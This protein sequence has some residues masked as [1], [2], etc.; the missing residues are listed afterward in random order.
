MSETFGIAFARVKLLGLQNTRTTEDQLAWGD[1][2]KATLHDCCQVMFV[3]LQAARQGST[4]LPDMET[5]SHAAAGNSADLYVRPGQLYCLLSLHYANVVITLLVCHQYASSTPY[6]YFPS[7]FCMLLRCLIAT[8]MPECKDINEYERAA[9]GSCLPMSNTS[10][11]KQ[12]IHSCCKQ[13]P[14][15]AS[16]L[17][18]VMPVSITLLGYKPP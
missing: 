11:C 10:I 9:A 4:A 2:N 3:G 16:A 14:G 8:T 1:D 12:I 7:S 17:Q 18:A 5:R 15:V 6:I 13:D